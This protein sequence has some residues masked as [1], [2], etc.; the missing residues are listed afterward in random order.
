VPAADVIHRLAL[1][2]HPEGGW[3]RE[4]HRSS[5]RVSTARGP[6]SALTDIYYLLERSQLSR[7][8][9]V[10]ADEAWHFHDGAPLQLYLYDPAD[11]LLTAPL[12]GTP[13]ADREPTAVVPAGTWQAARSQGEYSLA[14]CSVAPGF[15]FSG[16]R[17][18][19]D[20][21]D[22]RHHFEAAASLQALRALL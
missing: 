6:R 1:Q 21:P 8:H 18:V 20:L 15:E 14:G 4:I 16:F 7:W 13:A 11:R 9:V 2:P 5:Q 3:Y 17:Y 22:H 12:L 10:D 19:A